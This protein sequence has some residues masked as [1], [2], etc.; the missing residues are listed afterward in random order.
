[1]LV[2]YLTGGA[3]LDQGKHVVLWLS[4]EGVRLALR[5]YG[6][7]IRAGSTYRSS[8]CM[9]SSSRRVAASRSPI[10]FN[11]RGLDAGELVE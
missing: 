3:T 11:D 2:S 4:S 7:A 10:C 1:M 9:T 6:D 8:A 5:G